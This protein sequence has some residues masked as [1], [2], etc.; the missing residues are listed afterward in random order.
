[1]AGFD[2]GKAFGA[3]GDLFGAVGSAVGG[4]GA[5]AAGDA[6]QKGLTQEAGF[7]GQAADIE[8]EN[9]ILAGAAGDIQIAQQARKNYEVMSGTRAAVAG[10]GLAQTGSAGDILR[11]NAQQGSLALATLNVQKQINVNAYKVQQEAYQ[12]QQ[13]AADAAA[14]AAAGGGAMGGIGGALGALGSIAKV[15]ATLAPMLIP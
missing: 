15:G 5:M 11:E 14:Q 1:M 13:E 12:A 9:A 8:G 2:T 10:A 6:N 7:Y 4:L 3:A